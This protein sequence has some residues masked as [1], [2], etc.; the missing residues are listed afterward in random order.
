MLK[1][2]APLHFFFLIKSG[3]GRFVKDVL[4]GSSKSNNSGFFRTAFTIRAR[5]ICPLLKA[6]RGRSSS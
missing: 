2:Q 4:R 6:M 3:N 5:R 1:R